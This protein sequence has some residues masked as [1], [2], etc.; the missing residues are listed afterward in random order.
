MLPPAPDPAASMG[1][2][3]S[4][5]GIAGGATRACI[6]CSFKWGRNQMIAEWKSVSTYLPC[7]S[8]LQ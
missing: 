4:G 5:L 3:Q 6:G 8:I 2:D 1:R 7:A